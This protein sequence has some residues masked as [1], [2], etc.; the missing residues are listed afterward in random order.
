M[1]IQDHLQ[2]A[3]PDATQLQATLDK[4]Q[5]KLILRDRCVMHEGTLCSGRDSKA[6]IERFAA[7]G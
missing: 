7:L 1:E 3:A 4:W 6:T 2:A 5:W